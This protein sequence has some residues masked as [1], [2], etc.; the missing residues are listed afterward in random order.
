MSRLVI[1]SAGLVALLV[2]GCGLKYD[3]YLPENEAQALEQ[4]QGTAIGA[5][6]SMSKEEQAG[7]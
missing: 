3:L 2:T 6:S 7:Q 4:N 1:F 5:D